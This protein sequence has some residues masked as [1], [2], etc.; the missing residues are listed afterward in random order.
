MRVSACVRVCV[1]F[2]VCVVQSICLHAKDRKKELIGVVQSVPFV[3]KAME[4][5]V[6]RIK[7]FVKKH[8]LEK[9]FWQGK[10]L[11]ARSCPPSVRLSSCCT[12]V[13]AI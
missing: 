11:S 9:A 12:R 8:K 1:C 4:S 13:Q 5:L 7:L 10:A 3:R 6:L 2:V